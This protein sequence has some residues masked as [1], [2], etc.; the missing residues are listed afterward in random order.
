MSQSVFAK[1]MRSWRLLQNPQHFTELYFTSQQLPT[2]AQVGDTQKVAFTVRNLERQ[3]TSYHYKLIF[4]LATNGAENQA[5]DSDFM[6]ASGQTRTIS[7]DVVVPSLGKR[8]FLKVDLNYSGA[9]ADGAPLRP[10]NQSI[11]YWL[12]VTAGS[13][14]LKAGV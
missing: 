6:L 8:I 10:Q 4:G 3:T 5:G 7:Q 12:A 2:S 1:Q 14:T 11:Q 13:S 9:S